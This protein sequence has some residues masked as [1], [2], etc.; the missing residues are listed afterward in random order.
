[1]HCGEEPRSGEDERQRDERKEV[2]LARRGEASARRPGRRNRS[3]MIKSDGGESREG[4]WGRG[5][6]KEQGR[7]GSFLPSSDS[8]AK[9][10]R[11]HQSV[12]T[13]RR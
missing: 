9:Q 1:M 13:S 12:S 4:T 8:H 11:G 3:R 10:C 2:G 6:V 5:G 7:G